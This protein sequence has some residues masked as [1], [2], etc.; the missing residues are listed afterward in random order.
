MT[1][2]IEFENKQ[3]IDDTTNKIYIDRDGLMKETKEELKKKGFM[4]VE[5]DG[6][7][8]IKYIKDG[9]NLAHFHDT[10][11]G[12]GLYRSIITK[13]GILMCYSPPKSKKF[14]YRWK[15]SNKDME[16]LRITELVEG[17][18]INVFFDAEQDCWQIA[19][20][21][22]INGNGKFYKTEENKTF[23]EMF[24]EAMI[25]TGLK[26]EM[27]DDYNCYSFVLQHP[28][29]RIVLK[30]QKPSLVLTHIYS[31]T[32]I[33]EKQYGNA[34][35]QVDINGKFGDKIV[36]NCEVTKPR[37]FSL[38]EFTYKDYEKFYG[39]ESEY[40]IMGVVFTNE[41]GERTKIRNE[42]YE[43]VRELRGN[44]PK[45][46]YQFYNLRKNKRITEYL[47]YY[48]SDTEI[49]DTYEKQ[50]REFTS[51]LHNH[52]MNSYV[53][54]KNP[55][56]NIEKND[57]GYWVGF[58]NPRYKVHSYHLH[59]MF[60]LNRTEDKY[61]KITLSRVITYVN[62]LE[63]ARLMYSINFELRQQNMT[64]LKNEL[65]DEF[66]LVEKVKN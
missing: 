30:H 58:N 36:N 57:K 51:E 33:L 27:L 26:W 44:N 43:R 38:P 65:K 1:T 53:Y 56:S 28:N 50:V 48:P 59:N 61:Y 32:G 52:Y 54:S 23:R 11:K 22:R 16:K 45:I 10:G 49:F 63:P 6:Y 20:R 21:S 40:D 66:E 39:E 64:D 18:M 31:V 8:I 3:Y 42:N 12:K 17:T 47:H 2:A 13:N 34:I 55:N 15:N 62:N 4:N 29:N 24:L 35:N 46:Q 19:T 60:K 41:K 7:K 14:D 37:D 9:L 5:F 25:S